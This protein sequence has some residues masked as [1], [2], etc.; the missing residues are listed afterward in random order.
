[1]AINVYNDLKCMLTNNCFSAHTIST[2]PFLTTDLLGLYNSKACRSLA[3]NRSSLLSNKILWTKLVKLIN[4]STYS[5]F[6]GFKL[7]FS[8]KANNSLP[9]HHIR[10]DNSYR[11]ILLVLHYRSPACVQCCPTCKTIRVASLDTR[12][13]INR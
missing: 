10:R 12:F 2:W 1:M 3:R 7:G 4:N 8:C 11:S 5:K 13:C 9:T 6:A